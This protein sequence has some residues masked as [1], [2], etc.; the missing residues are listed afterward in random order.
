MPFGITSGS[1]VFWRA[2]ENPSAGQPVQSW[3]MTCWFGVNKHTRTVQALKENSCK[4]HERNATN[5]LQ[6]NADFAVS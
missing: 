4:E 1:S 5:C 2:R 3:W 6:G